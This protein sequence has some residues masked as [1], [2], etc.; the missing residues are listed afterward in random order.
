MFSR[1]ALTVFALLAAE[2]LI[3]GLVVRALGPATVVVA[4]LASAAIGAIMIRRQLAGIFTSGAT[5][6]GS[7]PGAGSDD[8]STG[9]VAGHGLLMMAGV[10]LVIPG[11][12]TSAVGGLLIVPPVRAA[13]A[14]RIRR[15]S[16]SPM[17]RFGS[18][19]PANGR[20]SQRRHDVVDVDVVAEDM[21]TSAR[22]E[23]H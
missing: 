10:L 20:S 9:R 14:G 15:W 2:L 13:V 16:P 18:P 5:I 1:A 3:L 4:L 7:P 6:S 21:P 17:V 11:F 8:A 23:L 12:L 19:V 22:S